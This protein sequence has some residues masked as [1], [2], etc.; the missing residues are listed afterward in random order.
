MTA[1]ESTRRF[2]GKVVMVTVAANG[3]GR[4]AALAAFVSVN[5]MRRLGEPDEVAALVA[6][7]LSGEAPLVTAP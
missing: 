6:F 7:L 2:H 1:T 4:A 5:P 3:F